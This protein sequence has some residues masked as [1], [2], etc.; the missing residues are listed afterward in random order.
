VRNSSI[1][2][3]VRSPRKAPSSIIDLTAACSLSL[4]LGN[5]HAFAKGEPV[6]LYYRRIFNLDFKYSNPPFGGV[7]ALITCGGME[8]FSSGLFLRRSCFHL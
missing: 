3:R 4:V 7:E 8:Y 6:R 5:Y 2:T 1:T